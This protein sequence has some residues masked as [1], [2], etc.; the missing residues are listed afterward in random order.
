MILRARVTLWRLLAGRIEP[1]LVLGCNQAADL[2]RFS[3]IHFGRLCKAMPV[4]RAQGVRVL[5]LS[6]L[7][8]GTKDS[9]CIKDSDPLV[10]GLCPLDPILDH[11]LKS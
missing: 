8:I 5:D 9:A 2:M 11:P 7:A 4:R 6:S 10:P 3:F 1:G